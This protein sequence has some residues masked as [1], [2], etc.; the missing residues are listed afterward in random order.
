[1]FKNIKTK[2]LGTHWHDIYSCKGN[3]KI[4]AMKYV[5]NTFLALFIIIFNTSCSHDDGYSLNDMWLTTG[6]VMKTSDYFYIQTD[7]EKSLWPTATNVDPE[8]LEDGSRV[9]VNYTILGD[10]SSSD[11]YDYYVKINGLEEILTKP[12][13]EF[14]EQTSEAIKDSIGYDAISIINYWFAKDYLNLEFEY[15]AGGSVVHFINLVK[16]MEYPETENGEIILELKHNKNGDSYNYKQWGIA[17]FSMSELQKE[18]IDSVNIL[19][20]SL[21]SEGEYTYNKV[22]TY[23]YGLEPELYQSTLNIEHFESLNAKMK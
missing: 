12:V 7:N 11:T 1:M 22:V 2:R 15:G 3:Y 16:D 6:T 4:G 5:K 23:D 17:S 9:L 21:N 20:R 8:L 19:V 13:F 14:T 10:T 18:G